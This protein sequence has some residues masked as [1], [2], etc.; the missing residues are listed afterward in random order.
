MTN[1]YLDRI[2]EGTLL[3]GGLVSLR[4]LDLDDLDGIIALSEAL[5]ESERYLRFFT[6]H[7]GYLKGWARSLADRSNRRFALGAF[8]SG[9]LIG[10]ASYFMCDDPGCAEVAI[11][12]AH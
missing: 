12:V 6:A 3:D 2:S 5:T 4:R 8:E 1:E 11:V 9:R 7:P 10:F